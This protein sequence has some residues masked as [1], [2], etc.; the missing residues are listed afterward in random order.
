ML[1]TYIDS[2]EIIT[3]IF[4]IYPPVQKKVKVNTSPKIKKLDGEFSDMDIEPIEL[5]EREENEILLKRR[6]AYLEEQLRKKIIDEEWL[7][8]SGDKQ[9]KLTSEEEIITV[10]EKL[11]D[12][13]PRLTKKK[14]QKS[15]NQAKQDKSE[16]KSPNNSPPSSNIAPSKKDFSESKATKY[17]LSRIPNDENSV[18]MKDE[19]KSSTSSKT[20][21]KKSSSVSKSSSASVSKKLSK[22]SQ[23]VIQPGT[24][25]IEI[26]EESLVINLPKIEDGTRLF[27][28]LYTPMPDEEITLEQYD[29]PWLSNKGDYIIYHDDSKYLDVKLSDREGYKKVYHISGKLLSARMCWESLECKAGSVLYLEK[30]L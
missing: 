21:T 26:D 8:P 10:S 9:P 3:S 4:T 29:E 16:D 22:P 14:S 18:S 23:S 1:K 7:G 30:K 2:E 12:Q 20:K 25:I 5:L 17:K 27:V 19:Q 11:T 13:L 24:K 28:Q 6:I 15:L